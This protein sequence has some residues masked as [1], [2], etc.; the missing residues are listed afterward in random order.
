MNPKSV[1]AAEFIERIRPSPFSNTNDGTGSSSIEKIDK[2][3]GPEG[4]AVARR[5]LVM[6]GAPVREFHLVAPRAEQSLVLSTSFT[7]FRIKV[8]NH[9]QF[10][11]DDE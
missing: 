11:M 5:P 7:P 3:V 4:W 9:Q 6:A 10:R 1:L 8:F 2:S